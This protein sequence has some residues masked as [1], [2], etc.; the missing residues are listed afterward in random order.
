MQKEEMPPTNQP[1]KVEVKINLSSE[2][3]E[4]AIRL[5]E[6][7]ATPPAELYRQAV[8]QGLTDLARDETARNV[9]RKTS[10][11]GELA[12]L[13][14]DMDEEQMQKAIAL[15]KETMGEG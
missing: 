8:E 2:T 5:A 7:K 3:V 1:R 9:W 13:I 14:N 4:F 12:R 11:R 15:L 10:M 6:S